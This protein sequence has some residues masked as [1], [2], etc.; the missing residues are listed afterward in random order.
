MI[1]YYPYRDFFSK[2]VIDSIYFFGYSSFSFV[3]HMWVSRLNQQSI[4]VINILSSSHSLCCSWYWR[5]YDLDQHLMHLAC[6]INGLMSLFNVPTAIHH[7]QINTTHISSSSATRL[8]SPTHHHS[9]IHCLLLSCVLSSLYHCKLLAL[10]LSVLSPMRSSFSSSLWC[11]ASSLYVVLWVVIPLHPP[12]WYGNLVLSSS[13]WKLILESL[14]NY[15]LFCM[16]I[17]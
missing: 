11:V 16:N 17:R 6:S 14:L 3:F 7:I 2:P 5:E 12:S 15:K 10:L 8:C 1:L 4:H 9:I 13:R